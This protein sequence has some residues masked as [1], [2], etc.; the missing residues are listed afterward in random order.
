MRRGRNHRLLVKLIERNLFGED[1]EQKVSIGKRVKHYY[2]CTTDYLDRIEEGWPYKQ[3][4]RCLRDKKF[5]AKQF[6]KERQ[7]KF[8]TVA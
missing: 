3:G 5:L 6:K 7:L 4:Y 1:E 8:A 2:P